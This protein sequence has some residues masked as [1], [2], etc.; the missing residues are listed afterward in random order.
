[1]QDRDAARYNDDCERDAARFHEMQQYLQEEQRIETQDLIAQL[2]FQHTH[3]AEAAAQFHEK[4]LNDEIAAVAIAK[5]VT[6]RLWKKCKDRKL[7]LLSRR[8]VSLKP[9]SLG[10]NNPTDK[11]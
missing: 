6:N 3:M 1:M 2:E 8:N 10:L 5:N 7:Q 11:N 9:R 4:Q